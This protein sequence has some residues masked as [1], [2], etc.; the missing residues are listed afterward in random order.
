MVNFV[1]PF[2][3]RKFK[4]VPETHGIKEDDM[5]VNYIVQGHIEE[6]VPF[7][8]DLLLCKQEHCAYGNLVVARHLAHQAHVLED[9]A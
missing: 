6:T 7:G 5:Q 9:H 2:Q 3:V 8:M 1:K 4:A